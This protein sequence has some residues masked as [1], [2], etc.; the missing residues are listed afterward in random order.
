MV[1]VRWCFPQNRWSMLERWWELI[2][3]AII[4][5]GKRQLPQLF[6]WWFLIYGGGGVFVFVTRGLANNYFCE[7]EPPRCH[8]CSDEIVQCGGDECYSYS[9]A[10]M[11]EKYVEDDDVYKAFFEKASLSTTCVDHADAVDDP[12]DMIHRLDTFG[13]LGLG[14]DDD[15][16]SCQAFFCKLLEVALTDS[17][18]T[19]NSGSCTNDQEQKENDTYCPCNS[20]YLNTS[21]S[22]LTDNKCNFAVA[23]ATE[24]ASRNSALF[25][26]LQEQQKFNHTALQETSSASFLELDSGE[27]GDG[28]FVAADVESRS[29][30]SPSPS[31]APAVSP[32]P[33]A[34]NDELPDYE[35]GDWFDCKCFTPCVDGVRKR[36]VACAS[37]SCQ[38]PKPVQAE[39]CTCT[40][41]ADC[42]MLILTLVISI[43]FWFQSLLSLVLSVSFGHIS[44]LDEDDL[45]EVSFFKKLIGAVC[46]NLPF[47]VKVLTIMLLFAGIYLMFVTVIDLPDWEEDCNEVSSLQIMSTSIVVLTLGLIVWGRAMKVNTPIAPWL[48]VPSKGSKRSLFCGP[49]RWMGP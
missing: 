22:I 11:M 40:Y 16:Y 32:T 6:F 18:L 39:R 14:E 26:R 2:R 24:I 47:I 45:A 30:Q 23:F 31:P 38:E 3:K 36:Q 44:N 4:S 15:D 37:T 46:K 8:S 28:T 7:L 34:I 27:D 21:D 13:L 25:R 20:L 42:N 10:V 17:D 29:L 48:Y 5:C 12:K 41:C 33:T 9:L 35:V 19:D 49:L 1:S 43:V